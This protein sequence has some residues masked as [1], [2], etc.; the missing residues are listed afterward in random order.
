MSQRLLS[1]LAALALVLATAEA[2]AAT[3]KVLAPY[4]HVPGADVAGALPLEQTR[5]DVHI[6]GVIA[7]VRVT[8]IYHNTGAK[9]LEAVYVFSGG[10][11]AAMFGMQMTIGAR[12]IVAKINKRAQARKLYEQ[13]RKQGQSA[14][15][16]EQQRPNVFQMNVA[17]ILPG[18]KIKVELDY[19]ELLTP[20]GGTYEF[21]YPGPVG[22]RY[23]TK[24]EATS[25]ASESWV[26]NPYLPE[27]EAPPFKWGIKAKLTAGLPIQ[28]IASPSHQVTP[29]FQ[30]QRV[31]E[32]AL[33]AS[34]PG[35]AAGGSGRGDVGGDRDFVVRYQ[36]AGGAIETGVLLYPGKRE[37]FFL[38]MMQ[39]PKRVAPAQIPRREYVFI[40]DVSGSMRGFPLDTSKQL[41]SDL[42]GGLRPTDTFNILVFAGQ[43]G[44]LHP[45]S[46]PATPANVQQSIAQVSSLQGGGGTELLPALQRAL[47]LPTSADTART[48]V[49]VTDGYVNVEAEALELIR[50]NLGKA[51]IFAFGIGSSVNRHLIET[52]A[53]VGMGEPFVV[54]NPSEAPSKAAKFK[55][56]VASP[57]LTNV[58]VAFKGGFR[59]YDVEP[60]AFPDVLAE[61]PLMVF[62]K[63]RGAPRG[64]IEVS[65]TTGAG[66]FKSAL[67]LSSAVADPGNEALRYLWARHRIA[68]LSDLSGPNAPPRV[69]TQITNLGL[70]YNLMTPYTS[71]VAIDHRVRN[72]CG[73]LVT[74]KQPLPLPA[75]V[76]NSA[77]GTIGY[78][79][80]S[81][82]G[83]GYGSGY[84]RLGRSHRARP[85]R[86]RMGATHISGRLPPEV[87]QR[88]VRQNF[89][90]FRGCYQQGLLRDAKLEGRVVVR[91]VIGRDGRV[92][93]V[94]V[95]GG[96]LADEG[97]RSCVTRA[98]YALSFPQ[99][100][101]GVVTVTYPIVFRPAAN[102]GAAPAQ[103]Q[104]PPRWPKPSGG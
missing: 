44:L 49:V 28:R 41:M 52:M 64:D 19:A 23:S 81:G 21:V 54:T 7:H 61:R 38:M 9:P 104:T 74:V 24:T 97:V 82:S 88:I 56:Y 95:T 27:G 73:K 33:G 39:P 77:L 72:Q 51:N 83:A 75:G 25:P 16:L 63:Y 5:A 70:Q 34:S 101:G 102:D 42:L 30:G 59:A 100:E 14:S 29:T 98:F 57:V 11:R 78:G 103:L 4:F 37:S 87:I 10:T 20:E 45:Q 91:F 46:I 80:G 69:V 92:S 22:P 50:K 36:L 32:V 13:A 96:D 48:F 67:A 6:A 93:K 76:E 12:K 86:V 62:G 17:N 89:G 79:S 40:V 55:D 71:F 3:D 66:P 65:G 84:G 31:A 94:K 47:A 60:S 99:P 8:Q 2:H 1:V 53:R 15:L 43:S 18:D 58:R 35:S 90:R 85:P 68:E 26:A